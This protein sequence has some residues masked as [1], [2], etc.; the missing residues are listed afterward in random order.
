MKISLMLNGTKIEREIAPDL[1]LIDFVREEGC[2]SVKRG[3]E[4]FRL[5]PVYSIFW[6]KNRSCPVP[7]LRQERTGMQ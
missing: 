2:Y 1:L 3:C 5:R 6:M 7:C 4:N